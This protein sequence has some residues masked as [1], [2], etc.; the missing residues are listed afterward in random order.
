HGIYDPRTSEI[1]LAS[2]GHPLPP[3]RRVN[4]QVEEA[5]VPV[6]RALGFLEDNPRLA[7]VCLTLAPGEILIL[8]TD[9]FTEAFAPDGE[10]MFGLE[11]L[12]HELGALL[13]RCALKNVAEELRLSVERFTGS[14][15]LQDD[16]TLLLLRR[17]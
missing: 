2:G 15:E 8:Y 11:R 13:G 10:T 9:G 17:S 5:A 3:L 7:D 1:I 12:S 6:G 4:G 16:L 14:A